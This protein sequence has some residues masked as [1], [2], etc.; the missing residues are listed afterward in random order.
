[1][2][3]RDVSPQARSAQRFCVTMHLGNALVN[4]LGNALGVG[5]PWGMPLE[6]LGNALDSALGEC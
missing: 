4:A 2:G 3:E 1:M 5:M 6:R